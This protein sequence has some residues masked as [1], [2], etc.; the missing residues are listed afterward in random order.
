MR[1]VS[2]DFARGD[3][4]AILDPDGREVA[5]GLVAYDAADALRIAGLKTDEIARVL[6]HEPR[7]AMVHRDDLVVSRTVARTE[8]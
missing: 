6:G 4:V 2:G 7:S 1:L 3:T 5:R 8:G